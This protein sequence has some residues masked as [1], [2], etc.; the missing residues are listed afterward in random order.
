[1]NYNGLREKGLINLK[2]SFVFGA[3]SLD[4]RQKTSFEGPSVAYDI[5]YLGGG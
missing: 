5:F 1:M 2:L 4:S 3:L